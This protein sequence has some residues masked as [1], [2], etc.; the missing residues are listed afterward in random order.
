MGLLFSADGGRKGSL[1]P[2][3]PENQHVS[4]STI[5]LMLALAAAVSISGCGKE[6]APPVASSAPPPPA[7]MPAP[8][9]HPIPS[10]AGDTV[11]L[12]GITKAEGGKTV[13]EVFAE[14]EQLAGETV[15]FRGKVVKTN[16]G[17]MGRNWLHIRDGSGAEGTNDV[18]VT[19]TEVLPNVGD[20]VLV[21]GVLQLNKDF[22][23]GYQYDLIIEDADVTVEATAAE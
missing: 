16:A 3:N 7:E 20:T 9:P 14:R 8:P 21:S 18:T 11:D 1:Q 15:V 17:I 2:R 6:Q 13:A 4:K 19:T 22:G 10:V 23:M 5:G 12:S